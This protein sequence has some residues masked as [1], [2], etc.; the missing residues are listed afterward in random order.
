MKKWIF[1][2]LSA[3]T[4]AVVSMANYEQLPAQMVV[5][6][7]PSET[8]DNWMSKPFGAFFLPVLILLISFVIL[9][10]VKFEKDDN[11]RRRMETTIGSVVAMVST[12]ILAVHLL[13]IAYNLGYELG[14][15]A[16]TMIMIGMIF[17]LLGNLMPKLPQGSMNW[18]KLTEPRQR[19]VSRFQGRVMMI[20]G[21]IFLILSLLPS[22]YIFYVFFSLLAIFIIILIT[23]TFRITR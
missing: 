10:S 16:L 2:V 4:A 11:K 3:I 21:F 1:P 20:F 7:S 18:P 15:S 8:P 23:S 17:I 6:F 5:H 13:I 19:K 9:L 14:V 22:S 12:I